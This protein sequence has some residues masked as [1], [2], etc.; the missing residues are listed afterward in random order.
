MK[1]LLVSDLHYRLRQYDWIADT[2]PDVDIVVIAGD[3]LDIRSAVPLPAQAVAV[4]AQIG[5]I[6]RRGVVLAASGNHDL[7]SRDAAGEKCTLWLHRV[8][9]PG[10][11]VDGDSPLVDGT[12]FTICPWW[13][14]PNGRRELEE[15]LVADAGRAKQQWVW[16]YHSPPSGSPLSWDGRRE[17]GD[18]VL[19]D[20]IERFRPQV[21]L[22]GHV[23]QA[24]FVDGGGWADRI[25]DTWVFNAGQQPGP[26]PSHIVIDVSA[27][28]ATWFASTERQTVRLG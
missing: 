25:G 7:D 13:D 14:G 19:A 8:R 4:S 2:A 20:W 6:G 26:V 12:L 10:L 22:T 27:Q 28:E 15:R 1:W 9:S 3:L 24:P 5:R 17:F 11:H 23:H 16:V 18:D 21:V